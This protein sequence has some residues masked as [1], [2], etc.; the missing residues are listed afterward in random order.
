MTTWQHVCVQHSLL[1]GRLHLVVVLAPA[2]Q[3]EING[4]ARKVAGLP[5]PLGLVSQIVLQ[6]PV[7]SQEE[8]MGLLRTEKQ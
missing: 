7:P 8:I 2:I 3:E 1:L 5:R 4:I 6:P